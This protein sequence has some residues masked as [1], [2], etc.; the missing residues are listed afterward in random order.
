MQHKINEDQMTKV[1]LFAEIEMALDEIRPYLIADGGNISL[2][3]VED[4]IA[5]VKLHGACKG[6]NI[7]HLT[8]KNGVEETIKRRVP[9]ILGVVEFA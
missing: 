9:Q 4:D 3:D 5:V 7:N 6:C 1:E 2:V 8:L